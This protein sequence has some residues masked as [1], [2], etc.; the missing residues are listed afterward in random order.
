MSLVPTSEVL[1]RPRLPR[2]NTDHPSHPARPLSQSTEFYDTDYDVNAPDHSNDE[3]GS[4]LEDESSRGSF[5]SVCSSAST[6][7]LSAVT[8]PSPQSRRKSGTTIST[9]DEAITPPISSYK[10]QFDL[11]INPPHPVQGPIGPHLFRSSTASSKDDV[12][13]TALQMSPLTPIKTPLHSSYVPHAYQEPWRP[14]ASTTSAES[15][16]LGFGDAEVQQWSTRLVTMWMRSAGIDDAIVRKFKQNDITGSILLDLEF[17]D[18]KELDIQSFG[19]RHQV[20]S[21][22]ESLRAVT[23]A[24]SAGS[25]RGSGARSPGVARS[26]SVRHESRRTQGLQDDCRKDAK[27]LTCGSRQQNIRADPLAPGDSISIVAIEEVVPEPHWCRKG[28]NCHTF[29]RRQRVLEQMDEDYGT[30]L[31]PAKGRH[32]LRR[33]IPDAAEV[34]APE[35]Q[36]LNGPAQLEPSLVGS[37]DALGPSRPLETIVQ[38]GLLDRLER[39]DLQEIVKQYLTLQHVTEAMDS[40]PSP[41]NTLEMFP[42]Q[43]V[44]MLPSSGV[45]TL[46]RPFEIPRSASAG[47]KSTFAQSR[48]PE[49]SPWSSMFRRGG[50]PASDMGVSSGPMLWPPIPREESQSVPPNMHYNQPVPIQINSRDPNYW[51]RPSMTLATV[52]ESATEDCPVQECKPVNV[53]KQGWM[54]KRK[55][56]LLRHDWLKQHI[57]LNGTQLAMHASDWK[58]DTKPLEKIDVG[59]YDVARIEKIADSKLNAALKTLRLTTG[60]N[61]VS[62]R[63][64]GLDLVPSTTER[65]MQ[66]N[67]EPKT[68]HF[69]IDSDYERGDWIRT[70]MLA[71]ARGQK[72][73]DCEVVINGKVI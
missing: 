29:K 28:E 9:P 43:H 25:R 37:S 58:F 60:K 67:K 63:L 10:N 22:I 21:Q 39:R 38:E 49:S 50:T 35:D 45:P 73:D 41:S 2:L 3:G 59:E 18:L 68:H 14:Q 66:A 6:R 57:R 32:M 44:S 64:Y 13:D 5:D 34:S 12:Y 51:R 16:V 33:L 55:N 52:R 48:S 1:V 7:L 20:W 24:S 30:S 72:A 56:K 69:A 62:E 40:T 53:E 26:L 27:P 4:D 17:G 36:D 70:L 19:K 54:R 42:Y 15:P 46:P 11:R 65:Q 23:D 71:K 61:S 47:P 8:H 31:S